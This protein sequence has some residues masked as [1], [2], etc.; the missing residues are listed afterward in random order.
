MGSPAHK[1]RRRAPFWRCW[2]CGRRLEAVRRSHAEDGPSRCPEHPRAEVIPWDLRRAHW[3]YATVEALALHLREQGLD[4][5]AIDAVVLDYPEHQDSLWPTLPPAD[6][7]L[8]ALRWLRWGRGPLPEQ[9]LPAAPAN[10][11]SLFGP[12]R[13][14][15]EPR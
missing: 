2:E 12:K 13:S 4:E 9:R 5:A 14:M 6:L 3:A 7:A 8:A 15:E 11:P 10:A 1:T